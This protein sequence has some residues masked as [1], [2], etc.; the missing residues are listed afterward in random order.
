MSKEIIVII[1]SWIIAILFLLKFIPKERMREAHISFLFSQTL[2]WIFEFIQVHFGL[3]EFP[4]REFHHTTK[5]SFSL[6]YLV[7]PSF[8][9]FFILLYPLNNGIFR[10]VLHYLIFSSAIA[11]YTTLVD[12]FTSLIEFKKW[13]WIIAVL[14]DCV[15]LWF[16]KKF[17]FWFRKELH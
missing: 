14:V 3:V 4:F 13:N 15:L 6:H 2:A 1:V 11:T 7:I 12:H 5:M 17:I 10:R 8:G 9:V 16:I